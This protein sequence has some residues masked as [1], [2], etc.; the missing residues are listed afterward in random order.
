MKLF[1]YFYICVCLSVSQ[2]VMEA[3]FHHGIILQDNCY[4][5]CNFFLRIARYKF[6]IACYK[7]RVATCKL[8]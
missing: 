7:V 6:A 3:C 5:L 1:L 8:Q 2:S 4:M